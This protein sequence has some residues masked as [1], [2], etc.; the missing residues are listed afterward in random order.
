MSHMEKQ[1]N[2]IIIFNYVSVLVLISI[3]TI[4]YSYFNSWYADP[5]KPTFLAYVY[6]D[7]KSPELLSIRVFFSFYLILTMLTPV[8]IIATIEMVKVV[9]A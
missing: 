8:D 1:I 7:L 5:E 2:W 6:Q 4:C 3:P 9:Y